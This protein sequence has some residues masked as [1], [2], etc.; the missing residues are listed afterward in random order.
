MGEKNVVEYSFYIYFVDS[1]TGFQ[2]HQFQ[3]LQTGRKKDV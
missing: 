1:D 2:Y 3:K